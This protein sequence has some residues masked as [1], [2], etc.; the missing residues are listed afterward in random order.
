[1]SDR[2]LLSPTKRLDT[3]IEEVGGFGRFQI[4]SSFAVMLAIEGVSF[5]IYPFGYLI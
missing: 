5:V 2:R 1:M 4:Y 3:L